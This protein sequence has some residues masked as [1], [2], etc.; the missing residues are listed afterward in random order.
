AHLLREPGPAACAGD[1]GAPVLRYEYGLENTTGDGADGA[2]YGEVE[3]DLAAEIVDDAADGEG[4]GSNADVGG[5]DVAGGENE[6]LSHAERE[7]A[8][9]WAVVGIHS[10]VVGGAS[11]G[12]G[13]CVHSG[14][15]G[16]VWLTRVSRCWLYVP[17]AR[18]HPG[19]SAGGATTAPL[20]CPAADVALRPACRTVH[21]WRTEMMRDAGERDQTHNDGRS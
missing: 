13:A 2:M 4:G 21:R 15:G 3:H 7:G 12:V 19:A 16:R 9:G 6:M 20:R 18:R 14:S 17:R 10:R 1:A 5:G 8:G 11:S